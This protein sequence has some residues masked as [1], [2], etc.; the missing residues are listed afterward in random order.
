MSDLRVHRLAVLRDNYSFVLE[1][2]RSRSAVLI[3][4]PEVEPFVDLLDEHQL[5]PHQIWLTHHHTDHTAGVEG[6]RQ[7]YG[8]L[9]VLA[10]WLDRGR[11]PCQTRELKEGDVLEFAGEEAHV[12]FCPGHS[13]GHIAYHFPKSGHVFSGDVVF[14]ASCGKVFEG[15]F[16]EMYESVQ[17][18]ANLPPE[19]LIWCGHEY[20]LG[21][22]KFAAHVDPDNQ[23][24]KE[25]LKNEKVP[26]V[27]LKLAVERQTSPFMRCGEPHY[28]QLTGQT[29]PA[30][31]F[32]ELRRRKDSF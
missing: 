18:I 26:T 21:N 6:L 27:P 30:Q 9:P 15:T 29:D 19:T 31:V 5:K 14:G 25:R 7:R 20:T 28:Q 4:P 12:L 24:L 17:K 13:K 10:S 3:D 22:L 8:E 32:A 16:E 23:A 11:V 2:T 1:D